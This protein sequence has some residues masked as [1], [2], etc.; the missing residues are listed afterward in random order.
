MHRPPNSATI[1]NAAMAGRVESCSPLHH[2]ATAVTA[3]TAETTPSI[4]RRASGALN[5]DQM[6]NASRRPNSSNEVIGRRNPT[7]SVPPNV[8]IT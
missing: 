3:G 8:N 5:V 4:Q 1:I 2:R 6:L 7:Q